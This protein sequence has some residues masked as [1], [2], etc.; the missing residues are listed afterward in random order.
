MEPETGCQM[1]SKDLFPLP[2]SHVGKLSVINIPQNDQKG[3]IQAL[4][5]I[6]G[7]VTYIVFDLKSQS[8]FFPHAV[9]H[10]T[11]MVRHPLLPFLGC[12]E[13]S[14]QPC[15]GNARVSRASTRA[16][17]H[18]HP[19]ASPLGPWHSRAPGDTLSVCVTSGSHD[20]AFTPYHR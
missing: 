1:P 12:R 8:H 16:A 2:K 18:P 13:D 14:E 9:I 11:G 6:L 19:E 15:G 20:T 17:Q 3:I 10:K 4:N 7:S 5:S